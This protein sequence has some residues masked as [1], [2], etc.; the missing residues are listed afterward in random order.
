MVLSNLSQMLNLAG[1]TELAIKY[2]VM[3]EDVVPPGDNLCYPLSLQAATLYNSKR[4]RLHQPLLQ[5]ALDSC[6]EAK[7]PVLTNT[8]WL[9]LRLSFLQE[10]K[11]KN[12][13]PCSIGL[14]EYSQRTTI[15]SI[16]SP[17]RRSERRLTQS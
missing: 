17:R 4:L 3:M 12:C 14:L 5:R 16:R 13:L 7:Q 11:A 1:Q 15:T 6:T 2:A 8:V 10:I 9:T